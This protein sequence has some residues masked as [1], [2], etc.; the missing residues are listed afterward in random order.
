MSLHKHALI[1]YRI[2]D[3]MLRDSQKP[4]PSIEEI[5]RECEEA[6]FGSENGDHI[7]Q[8][9]LEKDLR[10]MR[11]D[12]ELGY[13]API[14][15]SRGNKGYYYSN[16]EYTIHDAPLSIDDVETIKFAANTLFN[17][18]EHPLFEQFR[19]SIEK[20]F[21]RL[22]I[23]ENVA[24]GE[25]EKKVQF[26][27]FPDYPGKNYLP[28]VYEAIIDC[29]PLTMRYKKFNS[30]DFSSRVIHPYLLKEYKQRWYLIG[31]DDKSSKVRTFAL[32]RISGL[33]RSNKPYIE[34]QSFSVESYFRHAFGITVGEEDPADIKLFF[35]P[36]QIGYVKT[37]PLH[38]SQEIEEL[39]NGFYLTL[40][41]LPTYEFYERLLSFGANVKVVSPSEVK[42]ALIQKI[43]DNL[44]NYE[45]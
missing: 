7:C 11:S 15:Y 26:D 42:N 5:R 30:L 17:F 43:K 24:D 21:D 4:Y 3:R 12:A 28:I 41:V 2:I 33:E 44:A 6:L 45:K 14:K 35:P 13:E 20:I 27:T 37:Q 23:S 1:R 34:E 9:T 32:D 31:F 8:S 29:Y 40:K 22:N 36:H 25:I 16:K 18:R 38:H 19:F 39:D 10:A